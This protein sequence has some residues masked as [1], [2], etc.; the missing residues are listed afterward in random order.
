MNYYKQETNMDSIIQMVLDGNWTDLTKHTEQKAAS[1]LSE[2]IS[3]KKAEIVSRFND[4][5][6]EDVVTDE[7]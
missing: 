5:F 3:E 1:K 7:K 6:D 4:G 2:K